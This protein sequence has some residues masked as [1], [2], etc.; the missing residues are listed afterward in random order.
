M[1]CCIGYLWRVGAWM[2]CGLWD[3]V[4]IFLLL[5]YIVDNETL[6]VGTLLKSPA[7][8]GDQKMLYMNTSLG[9][10]ISR[11]VTQQPV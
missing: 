9:I 5:G 2:S 1:A 11:I 3:F 8:K 6:V 10:T 7:W 4:H